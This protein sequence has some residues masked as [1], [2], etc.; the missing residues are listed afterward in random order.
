MNDTPTKVAIVILTYNSCKM[1][2]EQLVDIAKLSTFGIEALCVVVDNASKDQ[3]NQQLKDYKLPNM[4]YVFLE[5]NLNLGYA[6]G[7]NIGIRYAL[8][9]GFEYILVMNND[10]VLSKNLLT[11][12]VE[13][14]KKNLDV[15]ICSPKIYFAKGYEFN[16]DKY[17]E[18]DKGK[19]I[20]Y[21]GGIIDKNN[22]YTSHKGVD[23]IDVGQFEIP[24]E[25]DS[26]SGA[27]MII[28][29]EV[30]KK[31]GLLNEK[32]FLYWEDVDLSMRV[33]KAGY[34]VMYLPYS[35]VWHKVSKSTGGSGS[36]TNDYFLTRNRLFFAL[37][38]SKLR[39]KL[40]V[41]RDTINLL[42]SGRKGQKFGAMDALL[43]NGGPGSWKSD[44]K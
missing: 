31:V 35:P 42:L 8:K 10:L 15:G 20:W 39:T 17:K 14:M 32:Y 29:K 25:T 26:A 5:S 21:A 16:K 6:G 38:Y 19:V 36:T 22:V 37:K 13:F 41:L 43:G 44:N 4:E 24:Q 34:K 18:S 9:N 1:T 40:A 3:T 23:E 12:L 7:N 30:F 27:C 33:K 11:I 28:R 2:K